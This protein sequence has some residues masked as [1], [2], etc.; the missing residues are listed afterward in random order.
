MDSGPE[1]QEK[2]GAVGVFQESDH[3]RQENGYFYERFSMGARVFPGLVA[4]TAPSFGG[5]FQFYAKNL[6]EFQVWSV[7]IAKS[8]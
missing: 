3:W 8:P 6:Y 1:G 5:R 4:A 2:E 7:L